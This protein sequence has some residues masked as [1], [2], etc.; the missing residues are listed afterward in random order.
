MRKS[1]VFLAGLLFATSASYSVAETD[2]KLYLGLGVSSLALDGERVLGVPTSSP[3]H[4]PKEFNVILGYQFDELWAA[5]LTLGTD[6]SGETSADQFMLN[7]YRF[8]GSSKWRP[9]VSAGL[10]AFS[11]DEASDDSTQQIQAGFG[12]SSALSDNL[13]FRAGY[14]LFSELSG[15]SSF[16]KALGISLNWHFG[17]PVA[18]AAT[19]QP[20]PVPEP[21]SVPENKEVVDTFELLVEFSFDQSDI[22]SAYEP[23]FKEIA[24]VLSSSPE[25]NM[26]IE[27]HTDWT[28]TDDYNLSLSE[29]RAD[30]VKNKFVQDYAIS[31]DRIDVIGYGELRPVEDNS[32]AAGRAR[33]RRAISVILR[34]RMVSE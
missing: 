16:D 6:F 33:N 18:T 30:A 8:F 28:G 15:D 3:G 21:E 7:G 11:V 10:S 19:T 22:T 24:Q 13:E 34:P 20:K 5:D 27:G 4:A 23:Q 32:T 17:K 12:I 26:T 14:Q 25:I 31:A 1:S 29:R 2:S 9:F